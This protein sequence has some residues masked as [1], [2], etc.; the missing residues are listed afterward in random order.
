MTATHELAPIVTIGDF[1]VPRFTLG[2]LRF[3]ECATKM[4]N[5]IALD[6][7][8]FLVLLFVLLFILLF[9]LST[10]KFSFIHDKFDITVPQGI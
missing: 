6:K 2:Q 1:A 8:I 9:V 4:V 5:I 3:R 7:L 10:L